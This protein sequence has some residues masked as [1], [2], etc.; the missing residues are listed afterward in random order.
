LKE[1]QLPKHHIAAYVVG[2]LII[3]YCYAFINAITTASENS[4][5]CKALETAAITG[6]Q[7]PTSISQ[8][9]KPAAFCE[10]G[11]HFPLLRTYFT[12]F[13]YGVLDRTQQDA[14]VNSLRGAPRG[15]QKRILVQFFDKENWRPWSD[16]NSGRSG[17]N[18]GPEHPIATQ[19][20]P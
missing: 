15:N 20:I 5:Q 2:G 14:I 16:P 12:V 3:A 17:G 4:Y 13:I 10:L 7:I 18:R 19:W 6:H 1:E 8:P 11:V 9:G